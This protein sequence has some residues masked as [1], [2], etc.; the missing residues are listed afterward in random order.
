VW[1]L[2]EDRTRFGSAVGGRC[3]ETIRSLCGPIVRCAAKRGIA[4]VVEHG[5]EL[6]A[7]AVRRGRLRELYARPGVLKQAFLFP[8]P[9]SVAPKALVVESSGRTPRTVP[10]PREVARDLAAWLGDWRAGTP[11]PAFPAARRLHD[12][13]ADLG[14][15]VGGD[16][17]PPLRL[18]D[19]TLV[20]HATVRLATGSTRLLFDPFLLPPDPAY[21]RGYQPLTSEELGPSD[22]VFITHSHPDHFDIG[23]LLRLGADTPI[24]VPAVRRESVLAV[25]MRRRLEEV[26]FRS[27]HTLAWFD[28]VQV[29]GLRVVALPFYGE[30]PTTDEVLHPEVR[31][32]GNIYLVEDAR[33]RY[34]LTADGGRDQAGD[35]KRVAADARRRFGPVDTVFGGYRSFALYPVHYLFSSIARFLPFVPPSAWGVRQKTMGDAA[36]LIDV[37]EI[38][39]AARVIPYADGGAPW[40][41]T[42]GLGPRL[43]VPASSPGERETDPRPEQV[44]EVARHRSSSPRGGT[45]R[46]AVAVSLLRPGDSLVFGARGK[47]RLR[48]AKPH[49]WPYADPGGEGDGD[50]EAIVRVG[51]NSRVLRK[52][53]LLRL[54]AEREVE[55]LGLDVPEQEVQALADAL[56][57]RLGL[58]SAAE[59]R[60]WLGREG[61]TPRRFGETMRALATVG[62]VERRYAAAIDQKLPIHAAIAG[63][64]RSRRR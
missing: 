50:V 36:D 22:A 7:Q 30:Q 58:F 45:I 59:T 16:P 44:V 37:A 5:P 41:W 1:P 11:T 46:S 40:Y 61:L 28:E 47:A 17:R 3:D 12:A 39:G 57:R 20:G 63:R 15:L 18:G 42:S 21:P 56:R 27:V 32:H 51:E 38:W 4:Y 8:P 14:V 2:Y 10:V 52:K 49:A 60:A 64:G 24:Y 35:L 23:T 6:L 13:L 26:G 55:R 33:R 48:R 53:V 54:L 43:D 34:V 29:G 9:A 25:D 31:N 19:A 62:V